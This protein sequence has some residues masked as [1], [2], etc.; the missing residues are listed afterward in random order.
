VI[1]VRENRMVEAPRRLRLDIIDGAKIAVSCEVG[2][3]VDKPV[4]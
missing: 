3:Q 4:H 1:D 2:M